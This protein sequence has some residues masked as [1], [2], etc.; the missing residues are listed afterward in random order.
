M[1]DSSMISQSYEYD[2]LIS[3]G[4]R[5][6]SGQ[7]SCGG[8]SE[9]CCQETIIMNYYT[10]NISS[11]NNFNWYKFELRKG[12]DITDDKFGQTNVNLTLY[13]S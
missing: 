10:N 1:I 13:L 9:Y 12:Q 7:W 5:L 3:S 4:E 2:Y 6:S 11:T 8:G